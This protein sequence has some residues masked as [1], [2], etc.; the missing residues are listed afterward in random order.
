MN[1]VLTLKLISYI[2]S[3]D[4]FSISCSRSVTWMYYTFILY[5]IQMSTWICTFFSVHIL[6]VCC[7]YVNCCILNLEALLVWACAAYLMSLHIFFL[8]N[9]QCHHSE[10]SYVFP[11]TLDV[12]INID[13]LSPCGGRENDL[14]KHREVSEWEGGREND[15][16]EHW[17]V[18]EWEEW[19]GWGDAH[20]SY[21]PA[22]IDQL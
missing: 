7:L 20:A 2:C 16:V 17:E 11:E 3:A 6:S 4:S 13:Y 5:S 1:V 8:V 22:D 10:S 18:I 14:V 12:Q 19:P 15:I 21:A 9:M